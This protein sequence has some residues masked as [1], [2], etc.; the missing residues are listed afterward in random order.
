MPGRIG[1]GLRGNGRGGRNQRSGGRSGQRYPHSFSASE[2][3]SYQPFQSK[4]DRKQRARNIQLY[5][6]EQKAKEE[7]QYFYQCVEKF[8]RTEHGGLHHHPDKMLTAEQVFA[9]GTAEG[10]NFD[11]YD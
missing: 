11:Q 3:Y 7:E 10:I 2:S 6:L 8:K 9:E 4:I 1:I 5:S